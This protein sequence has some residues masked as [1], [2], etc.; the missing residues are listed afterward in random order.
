[1]VY[2]EFCK[3]DRN[4]KFMFFHNNTQFI[5]TLTYCIIIIIIIITKLNKSKYYLIYSWFNDFFIQVFERIS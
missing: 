3:L 2:Y 1:M 5:K 4:K